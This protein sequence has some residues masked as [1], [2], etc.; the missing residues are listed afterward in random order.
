MAIS[1]QTFSQY[2][3][4]AVTAVQGASSRLL[5]LSVGSVLRAVLQS[6]AAMALWLQG[7]ALQVASLTR[8]AS[9]AGTDADSWGADFGFPR[10]GSLN[11][12][13]PVIF[14]R[15][16]STNQATIAIGVL[17]QTADG[18]QSYG[19][20][21][22][23]TQPTWNVAANAYI[24]PAGTASAVITVKSVNAA[25][26]ANVAAGAITIIAQS[27]PYI[28]TV[29]NAAPMTGGADA[30][31]DTAYH[32][33][34]PQ[35]ISSLSSATPGAI[36]FAIQS[37]AAN[38]NFTFTENKTLAGVAQPGFFYVVADNGTGAPPPS[39]LTSV[40]TAIE[41]VR[42]DSITYAVYPPSILSASVA[43]TL[44]TAT[45]FVHATV[46]A[47]VVAALTAQINAL[48]IGQSLPYNLLSS[49]AFGVSG[50]TNVTG[51]T[52]NGGTA[53]LLPNGAQS[54]IKAGGIFCT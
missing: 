30:E 46:V 13:G 29:S 23:I 24:I 1:S 25:A 31:S 33:R 8:F 26:A 7:I 18:T 53:D 10:I 28:D 37:V 42:G 39:F 12:T 2:V 21:A 4:A 50:V 40:A 11:A 43:M 16:T 51:I 3:S 54:I 41:A 44:T 52:L 49:I 38:V 48:K 14:S 35:F 45:G 17:V 34:F 36:K 47:A 32:A 6:T 5:D 27:I 22:D 19:A 9:S 20:I 15:F